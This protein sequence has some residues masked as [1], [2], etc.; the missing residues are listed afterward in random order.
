MWRDHCYSEE[1]KLLSHSAFAEEYMVDKALYLS[2]RCLVMKTV[3]TRYDTET[4][5]QCV[6]ICGS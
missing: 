1:Q 3:P 6:C 2:G 5:D 4:G